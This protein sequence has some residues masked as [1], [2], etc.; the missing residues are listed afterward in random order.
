MENSLYETY[1]PITN[2]FKISTKHTKPFISIIYNQH[3]ATLPEKEEKLEVIQHFHKNF[4]WKH[5]L[6]V[7]Y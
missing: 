1:S 3:K 6:G 2:N 4:P 5:A 7:G